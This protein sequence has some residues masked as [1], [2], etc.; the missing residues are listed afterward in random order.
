MDPFITH[1]GRAVSLR[2]GNVDTDQIIPA[3]YLKRVNR[4]GFADGFSAWRAG[5]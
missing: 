3:E 2:R 4:V 5:P 1:S